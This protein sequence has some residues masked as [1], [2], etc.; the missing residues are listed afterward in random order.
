M[1][2]DYRRQISTNYVSVA[3][4]VN[5]VYVDTKT[6]YYG[7]QEAHEM[8]KKAWKKYKKSTQQILICLRDKK[9]LLI[10]CEMNFKVEVPTKKK[11]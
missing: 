10:K 8:F 3:Y 2:P 7:L 11:R 1:E 4:F 6:E 9:H 5:G